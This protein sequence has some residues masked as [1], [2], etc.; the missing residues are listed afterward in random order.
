MAVSLPRLLG[1]FQKRI[2]GDD[3]LLE[4]ARLRFSQAG[5]GMEIYGGSVKE[6]EWLLGFA[7]APEIPVV[8][9]LARELDLLSES[10]RRYVKELVRTFGD[11]IYGYV[12]HDRSEYAGQPEAFRTA[13]A[14]L[15]AALLTTAGCPILFLE[16]A[17]G[18]PFERYCSMIESGRGLEQASAC[19]DIGHLGIRQARMAYAEK[20][21][22]E[23]ICALSPDDPTL[24]ELLNDVQ[25]AV[26][27]VPN[28]VLN[29]VGRMAKLG[30]PLHFH[31]HDGHPLSTLSPFGV[32]DHQSFFETI[33]LPFRFQGNYTLPTMFGPA[34]LKR[35]VTEACTTLSPA[36]LSFTLEIHPARRREPLADA[37]SLFRHWTDMANAE[38]MNGWLSTLMDNHRLLQEVCDDACSGSPY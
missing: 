33:E 32:S 26:H 30:K 8:I 27:S 16:Y 24:P 4:L 22:G 10:N 37:T 28:A 18:L 19:L 11:R 35:I 36:L 12:L 20:H 21:P 6:V 23:D 13:L 38:R 15:N 5:M 9:H 17:A 34:G 14:E 31:L 29:L 3:A 1:L 2:E 25:T 7:P